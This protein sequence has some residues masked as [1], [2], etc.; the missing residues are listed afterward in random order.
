MRRNVYMSAEECKIRCII[1]IAMIAI[2]IIGGIISVLVP[3]SAPQNAKSQYFCDSRAF[4]IPL[5]VDVKN[6]SDETLYNIKG[7]WFYTFED[8]LTMNDSEGNTV[9]EMKDNYNFITQ[10]DH[11]I[12]N[13]D[14]ALYV[15][16]GKFKFFGDSYKIYNSDKEQ[17]A[18]LECNWLMTSCELRDMQG[19]LMAE[20]STHILRKDYIISIYDECTIDE[21]SVLLLFASAESDSRADAASSSSSSSSRS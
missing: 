3:L 21:E 12:V 1:A 15:M 8:N 4:S 11:A 10:N 19:N 20:Y 9:R 13:N 17:V 14:G 5:D 18:T 7:E 16:E 6:M 2:L